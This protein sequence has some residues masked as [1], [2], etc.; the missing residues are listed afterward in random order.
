MSFMTI[1]EKQTHKPN[2]YVENKSSHTYKPNGPLKTNEKN[3]RRSYALCSTVN[4]QS[5]LKSHYSFIIHLY[6]F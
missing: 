1:F 5:Y 6:C 3:D 4:K 2:N